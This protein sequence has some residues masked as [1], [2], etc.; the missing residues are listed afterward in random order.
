MYVYD[1]VLCLRHALVMMTSPIE[2]LA[3]HLFRPSTARPVQNLH[4][5]TSTKLS[6]IRHSQFFFETGEIVLQNPIAKK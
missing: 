3:Q 2:P 4:E 6:K 5:G 1:V